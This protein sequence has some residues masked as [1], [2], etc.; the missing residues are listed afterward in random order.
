MLKY[1]KNTVFFFAD[2]TELQQFCSLHVMISKLKW[3]IRICRISFFV[4]C[5]ELLVAV[6]V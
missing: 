1:C 3:I 2:K 4:L 5:K 6:Y